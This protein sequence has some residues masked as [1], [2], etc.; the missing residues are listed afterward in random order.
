[1]EKNIIDLTQDYFEETKDKKR[2]VNY[3]FFDDQKNDFE[4]NNCPV[5]ILNEENGLVSGIYNPFFIIK[6][7]FQQKDFIERLECANDKTFSKF[8][9]WFKANALIKFTLSNVT[10]NYKIELNEGV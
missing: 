6:N 5:L 7:D 4:F 8:D 9:K 10:N 1:M 3:R 2:T